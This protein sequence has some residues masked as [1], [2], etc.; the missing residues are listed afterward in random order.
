MS[1]W[2]KHF[3]VCLMVL[4]SAACSGG[5]ENNCTA[6][7]ACAATEVE[8]A[9]CVG[10]GACEEVTVCNVTIYCAPADGCL[11][12]CGDVTC[13]TT[14]DCPQ[15][16]YCE[17]PD[18][19]C[20]TGAPGKCKPEGT[21]CPFEDT[22]PICYCGGTVFD[23]SGELDNRACR[24]RGGLD[25]DAGSNC[26]SPVTALEC[27]HLI[28]DTGT[29]DFCRKVVDSDGFSHV[30][31]ICGQFNG[32]QGGGPID[33]ACINDPENSE[34]GDCGSYTKSCVDTANGPVITCTQ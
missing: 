5:V 8:V 21:S 33:C 19:L 27:G 9:S 18:G 29:D 25:Y 23:G 28:C 3:A 4:A 26:T 22:P 24:G 34:V 17:F 10:R 11:E 30:D 15:F 2:A 14:S 20:G 32:C 13:D 1:H 7:P 12:N 31:A 6:E 16:Y